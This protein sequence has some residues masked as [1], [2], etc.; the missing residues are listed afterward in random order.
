MS[1]GQLQSSMG[2]QFMRFVLWTR[3]QVAQRAAFCILPNQAR[4]EFFKL[5]TKTQR[6]VFTV[7]NCPARA[8]ADRTGTPP[9]SGE[10]L[11]LFY[12]GSIVPAPV[13]FAILKALSIL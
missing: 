1:S 6:P 2:S 12:H 10:Q 7:W 9:P 5:S 13:P 4:A 8:E 11:V 3:R